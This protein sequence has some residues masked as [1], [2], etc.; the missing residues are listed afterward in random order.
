MLSHANLAANAQSIVDY[1]LRATDSIV[2]ACCRSTTPTAL[3]CCTRISSSAR[4]MV[5]ES[6]LVFPHLVVAVA[7]R[8]ERATGF[9]G[10]PSTFALLLQRVPL[11][12]IRSL[13]AALPDAG[14]RRDGAAR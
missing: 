8:S 3:R 13:V 12:R 5:L 4:C 9:S 14:W 10:V 1:L 7:W 6:N 11:E 2:S